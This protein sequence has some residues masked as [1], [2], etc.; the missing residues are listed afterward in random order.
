MLAIIDGS[1]RWIAVTQRQRLPN[2]AT[3]FWH[4]LRSPSVNGFKIA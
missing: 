4:Y 3:K 2:D 1:Y